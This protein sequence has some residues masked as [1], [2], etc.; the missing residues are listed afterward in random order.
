[1]FIAIKFDATR[2]IEGNFF[3]RHN[4]AA[5]TLTNEIA[6]IYQ[7]AQRLPH[8]RTTYAVLILQFLLTGYQFTG[9]PSLVMQLLKQYL[10]ELIVQWNRQIS[11]KLHKKWQEAYP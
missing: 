10:L 5:P 4:R 7:I 11:V 2:W 3:A 8:H 1:M 6:V 9:F